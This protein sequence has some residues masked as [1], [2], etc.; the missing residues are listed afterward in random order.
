MC[1]HAGRVCGWPRLVPRDDKGVPDPRALQAA[2]YFDA[3]NFAA[4]TKAEAVFAVGFIDD[5]CRP[6]SVYAAYNRLPGRKR[7]VNEPKITHAIWP[8]FNDARDA[9][10]SAHMPTAKP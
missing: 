1:E 4:R 5:V 6:T 7:I 10:I 3:V 9:L 2:R 8:S